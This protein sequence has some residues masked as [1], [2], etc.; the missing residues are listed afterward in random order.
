MAP[1]L[2]T[3]MYRNVAFR[4]ACRDDAAAIVYERSY[5][6]ATAEHYRMCRNPRGRYRRMTKWFLLH[7]KAIPGRYRKP[8]RLR[9]WYVAYHED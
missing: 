7:R 9:N 2:P 4:A 1:H 3:R 8:R 6:L 5:R